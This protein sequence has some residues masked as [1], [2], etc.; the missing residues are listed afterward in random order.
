MSKVKGRIFGIGAG[1]VMGIYANLI[2]FV[3]VLETTPTCPL[4][5]R[6][7]WDLNVGAYAHLNVVVDFKTIGMVPTASTTL[8]SAPTLTQCWPVGGS[9]S[10][11]DV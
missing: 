10:A 8:L 3:A 5:S 9:G 4:Q 2:E 6:E 7:W 1:A 11:G